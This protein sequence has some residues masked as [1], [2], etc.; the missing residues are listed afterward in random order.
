[1]T[2]MPLALRPQK[3]II[4]R[5]ALLLQDCSLNKTKESQ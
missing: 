2:T 1:M 4:N 5:A 3:D